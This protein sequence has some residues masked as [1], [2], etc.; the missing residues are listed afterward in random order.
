MSLNAN[1]LARRYDR[2]TPGERVRATLEASARDDLAERDRL[3]ASCPQRAYRTCDAAFLDPL[4]ASRAL[5][6]VVALELVS[7]PAQ[8]LAARCVDADDSVSDAVIALLVRGAAAVYEAFAAVCRERLA[9]EPDVVLRAH[10][11]P[12]YVERLGVD[13]VGE[14]EPDEGAVCVWRDL[15]ERRW[16]T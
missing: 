4:D 7:L 12:L 9:V 2:L 3:V 5:A 11:G 10:L 15:F 8:L 16:L 1:G 13:L 14:A 6:M